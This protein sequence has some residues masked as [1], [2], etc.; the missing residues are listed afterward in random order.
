MLQNTYR[1]LV[2]GTKILL[3]QEYRLLILVNKNF[4]TGVQAVVPHDL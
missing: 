2:L 3:M 1:L 4:T